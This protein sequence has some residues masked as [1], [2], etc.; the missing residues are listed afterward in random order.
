MITAIALNIALV[1]LKGQT[2]HDAQNNNKNNEWYAYGGNAGGSRYSGLQQIN[3]E[4]VKQLQVAW[5]YQTGE[6]KKYEGTNAKEKAAFEATPIFIDHTLYFSTPSCRVFAIDA[7]SGTQK[8]IFDPKINL[9][10]GFSEITSRGVSAWP[11]PGDKANSSVAKRIFIAT[12]DGRLIALDAK[13]GAPLVY[14]GK[15]GTVSKYGKL[16]WDLN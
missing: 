8:W 11:A 12:L 9:K 14:V 7:S 6:L 13:N 4:N 15:E 1:S 3:V 2:L 5:T 10:N 16:F